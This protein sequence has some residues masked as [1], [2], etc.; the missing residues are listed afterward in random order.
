MKK[1]IGL[2]A[3]LLFVFATARA[4]LCKAELFAAWSFDKDTAKDVTDVSGKGHNGVGKN[5]KIVDGK[6]GKAMEFDGATSQ[7]EVPHADD[8]NVAMVT[9]EAWVKPSKYNA[10][11]AV[12]QKWGDISNRRQYLLC[13]VNDKVRFYMSGKGNT[14]PQAESKTA[15]KTGEWTHIAGTYDGKTIRVYVNGKLDGEKS[16]AQTTEGLFASNIPVWIGG[17]GPDAEFGDNR[18]FPG[19]IDEVRFWNGP[20]SEAEIQESM[21]KPT[22]A[23]ES[24]GKLSVTWGKIKAARYQF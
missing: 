1:A 19:V 8:L 9:V 11:S 18:H 13:F 6:F 5:T 23:V 20:L 24:M 7:V 15:V 2:L 17:Y 16:D 3:I 12:A 4:G 10:L 14:W 21:N 22:T